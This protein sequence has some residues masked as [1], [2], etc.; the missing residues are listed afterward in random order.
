M[1]TQF[2]AVAGAFFATFLGAVGSLFFKMGSRELSLDPLKIAKNRV[3]V[4]GFIVY[5]ISAVIF[6]YCLRGGELSVLYPVVASSYIWVC[7]LS[8]KF[9]G[10][11]MNAA[12]WVGILLIIV[13][14][15]L[16]GLGA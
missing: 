8:M 16:I 2:W 1:T 12:K 3:L 7:L 10:E 9:L 13:G 4:A 6:V 11:K 14:V 5:G 15:S